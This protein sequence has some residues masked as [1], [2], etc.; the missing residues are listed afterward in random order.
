[1][2]AL[3]LVAC[4]ASNLGAAQLLP[5]EFVGVW[6]VGDSGRNECTK[7][8]WNDRKSDRLMNV[9]P[10]SIEYWESG[11]DIV[12]V[13]TQNQQSPEAVTSKLSLS[14]SGEGTSWR[15]IQ[16]WHTRLMGARKLLVQAEI[17]RWDERDD[18]GKRIR[19]TGE[20][21]VDVAVECK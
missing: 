12:G 1:M 7:A 14:C 15:S 4:L 21:Y 6:M 17:K 16:L 2:I 3:S 11:C 20:L 8:D 9:S 18:N 13:A 19:P 5:S 10:R